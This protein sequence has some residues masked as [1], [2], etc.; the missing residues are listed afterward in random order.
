MEIFTC[1]DLSFLERLAEDKSLSRTEIKR[2]KG[3]I[4]SSESYFIPSKKI[5]YLANLSINHAAEEASHYVRIL[6]AGPEFERKMVDAFYAN[7]LHEA[8]GFFGSKMINHKRKCSH[9][10]DFRHLL[11][12]LK[13]SDRSKK[14]RLQMESVSLILDHKKSERE[15]V[16]ISYQR[17]LRRNPEVF[18]GVTHGLGYILGDRLYYALVD[19]LLTKV[20]AKSLFMDRFKEEGA[21]FRAYMKLVKQTRRIKI[22]H[23]V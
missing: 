4:L 9:E 3:Q 21:A 19:G 23:R 13:F 22:P 7:I 2:I 14:R 17:L 1:G 10:K 8:L 5:V 15:G 11:R 6:T 20:E 16:P 12:Y 18:M